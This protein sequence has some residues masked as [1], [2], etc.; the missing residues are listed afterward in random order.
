[1]EDGMPGGYPEVSMYFN[2]NK[3]KLNPIIIVIKIGY[4]IKFAS[5]FFFFFLLVY[6]H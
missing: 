3:Y 5:V 4:L 6:M 1:M 2:T